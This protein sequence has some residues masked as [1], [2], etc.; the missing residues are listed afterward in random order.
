MNGSKVIEEIRCLR[1]HLLPILDRLEEL[2][3]KLEKD[4]AVSTNP[5]TTSHSKGKRLKVHYSRITKKQ[6]Y[7]QYLNK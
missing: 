7:N 1:M 6:A 5:E 3:K 4:G 2:E